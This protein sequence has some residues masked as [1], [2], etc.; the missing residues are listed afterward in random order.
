MIQNVIFCDPWMI[1]AA[2]IILWD[3]LQRWIIKKSRYSIYYKFSGQCFCGQAF[4]KHDR[5][6][7]S[8]CSMRCSGNDL[9]TCGGERRNNIYGG[10]YLLHLEKNQMKIRIFKFIST[11]FQTG[12]CW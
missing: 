9:E 3:V 5:I 2:T 4:G 12:K 6:S 8:E 10:I 1:I 7:E 11:S